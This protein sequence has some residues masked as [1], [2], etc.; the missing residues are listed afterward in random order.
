MLR[1]LSSE[2][3]VFGRAK[4]F[5]GRRKW[6]LFYEVASKIFRTGAAIYTAVVVGRST[7]SNRSKFEFQVL[8]RRFAATA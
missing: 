1:I 5:N 8:L 2:K 6:G 3:S 4:F 7:G